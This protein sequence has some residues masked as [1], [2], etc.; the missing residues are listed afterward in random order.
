MI[1]SPES[2]RSEA[3]IARVISE[4]EVGGVT[5]WALELPFHGPARTAGVVE[6]DEKI[7][8]GRAVLPPKARSG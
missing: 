1:S 8:A 5:A 7:G 6:A 3:A 4:G 2:R